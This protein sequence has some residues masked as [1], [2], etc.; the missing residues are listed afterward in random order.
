MAA[1]VK[2]AGRFELPDDEPG[3]PG[4]LV[5][6]LVPG[7]IPD[8][9]EPS[10]VLA[11]PVRVQLDD[12]GRFE[13]ELRATD[14]PDLTAHVSG[15]LVYRVHRTIRGGI[16]SSWSVLVPTPGPW[17]WTA[18]APSPPD[19]DAVVLPVPGPQGDQGIQGE[20]GIQGDQGI[21]GPEGEWVQLTQAEYN[22]L[23]P[24]DP[25]VLYVIVG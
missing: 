24:A 19:S 23:A 2:V 1:L 3:G 4:A 5:W 11:G 7:D 8:L 15:A 12:E 9:A 18:L 16:T 14:D 25:A 21:Q 13:V 10:T 17:D 22:A 20:Q 6:T